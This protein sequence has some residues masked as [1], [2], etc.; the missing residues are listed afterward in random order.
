MPKQCRVKAVA[1]NHIYS[2]QDHIKEKITQEKPDFIST[3]III[4]KPNYTEIYSDQLKEFIICKA[5][6]MLNIYLNVPM[7]ISKGKKLENIK[8][9]LFHL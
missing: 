9:A 3:C 4:L 5:H 6:V 1:D 2:S 8:N 7:F